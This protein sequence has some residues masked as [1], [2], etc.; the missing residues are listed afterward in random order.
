M[1]LSTNAAPATSHIAKEVEELV[2]ALLCPGVEVPHRSLRPLDLI[3]VGTKIRDQRCW[4]DNE[5]R[6]PK[7]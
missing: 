7:S 6:P 4:K 5:M 3:I 2:G 1:R